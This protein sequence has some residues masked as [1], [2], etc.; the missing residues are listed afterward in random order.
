MDVADVSDLGGRDF[1]PDIFGW[2]CGR[3]AMQVSRQQAKQA[4]EFYSRACWTYQDVG[5]AMGWSKG[6]AAKVIRNWEV[7]PEIF[8]ENEG[9]KR[10]CKRG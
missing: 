8:L 10:R 4:A 7:R 5:D 1:M 6:K 2:L 3:C 9:L